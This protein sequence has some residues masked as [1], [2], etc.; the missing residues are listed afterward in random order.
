MSLHYNPNQKADPNMQQTRP[1]DVNNYNTDTCLEWKLYE[2]ISCYSRVDNLSPWDHMDT[3]TVSNS[4]QELIQTFSFF[5]LLYKILT[6]Q[7]IDSTYQADF[8]T[9]D[10]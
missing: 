9:V 5:C 1:A 3:K 2:E 10:P 8:K 7:H 6:N 4:Q